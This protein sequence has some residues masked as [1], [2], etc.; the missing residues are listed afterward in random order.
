M[1]SLVG[2]N[3]VN[4]PLGR[5]LFR[6]IAELD[7]SLNMVTTR[8]FV[9][10]AVSVLTVSLAVG[11]PQK[12]GAFRLSIIDTSTEHGRDTFSVVKSV[13]IENG[14]LIY[15]EGGRRTKSIRKEYRLTGDE[16]AEIRQ[17]VENMN[18]SRAK[19]IRHELAAGPHRSREISLRAQIGRRTS[20]LN[21]E[22]QDE[23]T[24]LTE[25]STY[26][27]LKHLLDELGAIVISKES[28]N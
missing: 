15:R 17:L 5:S 4:A 1:V 8:R 6:K 12:R 16:L 18:L 28:S 19:S 2:G 13:S 27:K 9:W 10:L 25:D 7:R 26:A 11:S 3:P 20:S 24:A 22:G 23:S 14:S 21:I